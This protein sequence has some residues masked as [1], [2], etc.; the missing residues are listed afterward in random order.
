MA[1]DNKNEENQPDSN[2]SDPHNSYLNDKIIF[3]LICALGYIPCGLL[4][5]LP[6]ILYSD[7]AF[8]KF[9]SNQ[10]LVLFL[11]SVIC[12]TIFGILIMIPFLSWVMIALSSLFGLMMLIFCILGIINVVNDEQK[13]LPVIGGINLIK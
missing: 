6:L 2:Q 4:F 13:P 1:T 7:N 5:F 11:T 12:E 8:A 9:H 3:K 10:A